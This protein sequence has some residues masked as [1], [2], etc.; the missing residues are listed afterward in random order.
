M[1]ANDDDNNIEAAALLS[2]SPFKTTYI[3]SY[4]NTYS[5]DLQVASENSNESRNL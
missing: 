1:V 5:W 2:K 3:K 4:Y